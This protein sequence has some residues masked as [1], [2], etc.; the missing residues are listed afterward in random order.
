MASDPS[1]N[2]LASTAKV[3]GSLTFIYVVS[4]MGRIDEV[5]VAKPLGSGLEESAAK[6]GPYEC[7]D[8]GDV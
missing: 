5:W 6:T 4:D 2:Q 7:F 1:L 3:S 8:P